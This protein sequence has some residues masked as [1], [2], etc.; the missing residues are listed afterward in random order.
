MPK[1]S[2]ITINYNNASGLKK[3]IESVVSQSSSDFE[4]IIID[5]GSTDESVEIIKKYQEKI[6]HWISE[7]DNGIYHAMNKGILAAKGEYCQFLNSGDYFCNDLVV[8]KML[9][10]LDNESILSGNM[11]KVSKN[12]SRIIDKIHFVNSMLHFYKGTINHSS[13]L[14]K[15][16]LFEKYGNYDE[17][18]KIVSDWKF[19]LQTIGI[20]N[21][22]VKY[23][24]I[25]VTIFD[26]TGIS[27]TNDKLD[28]AERR[29]VLE[30][31]LPQSV[32][33]DYD[34]H[35]RDIEMIKRIKRNRFVYK[36]V[37]FLERVLF[38][39]EKFKA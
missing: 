32:L 15:R 7:K 33:L 9:S 38:K 11:I 14:I 35:W 1:L 37:W 39:I 13:S 4:Y 6:T 12:N 31:L 23:V 26:T 27:S 21:E 19:F 5:G 28:K 2:I 24:D 22:S 17:N 10:N 30:E 16:S 34:N 20:G 36:I 25:D 8:E 3:T 18:L 29:K